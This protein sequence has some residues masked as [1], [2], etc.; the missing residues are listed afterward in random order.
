MLAAMLATSLPASDLPH[1]SDGIALRMMLSACLPAAEDSHLHL[2]MAFDLFAATDVAGWQ[3][4][5][6]PIAFITKQL[7]E[8]DRSD[9]A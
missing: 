7:A 2:A 1:A 9:A 6:T 8:Q 4:R 3:R 5:Y